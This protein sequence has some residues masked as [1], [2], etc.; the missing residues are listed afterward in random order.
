MYNRS[1]MMRLAAVLVLLASALY[2]EVAEV[3]LDECIGIAL[4]CNPDARSAACRVEA[5]AAAIDEA[6]SAF[7]PRV[8]LSGGY[9]RTDN[10]PQA[11]MMSL[12]Q[13]DL[14]MGDPAFNPNEP[15]D[16]DNV[17]LSASARYLLLDGRRRINVHIAGLGE[18]A[19]REQLA[20]VRNELVY[21]VTRG[22]YGLLQSGAFVEVRQE[23]VRSLEES[24]RVSRERL[25]AGSAVRTDVL[26]VEV[27]LAQAR[28]DLIRAENGSRLAV[29]A[30]NT[31]IGSN[32]VCGADLPRPE[33]K[34]DAPECRPPDEISVELRPELQAARVRREIGE[35]AYRKAL[36][37][38]LPT[39]STFG[40][41]D[42]D[43]DTLA[44]FEDSYSVGLVLEWELFSGWRR[45]AAAARAKAEWQAAVEQ[46]RK[47]RNELALDARRAELQWRE[48]RERISVTAKSVESAE[49]ALRITRDRYEQGA[50]DITELLAAETRLSGIRTRDIA[51]YYDCLV[52]RS[53]LERA[54]GMLARRYESEE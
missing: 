3:D 51:A 19:A 54:M 29:A 1:N 32:V 26:N 15:D 37:D 53:N 34:E 9:S 45:P 43:S 36:R 35:S 41:M 44:D 16:T 4:R 2:G 47:A 48:A 18:A 33:R 11:F 14:R 7:Y 12:N 31:A 38:Y 21:Q 6:E 50:A 28:E 8:Q 17:R 27:E 52:A 42:R 25:N 22:Y 39:V 49:E 5:A 10:P 46:E 20:A 23:S 13:R 30:L 40:S 24:L